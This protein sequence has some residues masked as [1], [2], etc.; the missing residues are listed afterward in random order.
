MKILI[1]SPRFPYKQGKADSMTVFHL[2]QFLSQR[3]HQVILATF[4]QKDSFPEQERTLMKEMCL[5]VRTVPLKQWRTRWRL[6][7]NSWSKK[8]FQVA[9]YWDQ[10][11][12]RTVDDLIQK[13]QPDVSY[14]HLIRTA[15]YLSTYPDMLKV[16]AMQ[17]AQTL[18][19]KRLI[20]H[21]RN[22]IRKIFYTQEYRRVSQYEPEMLTRFN[23][24]LLISPHDKEAIQ[25]KKSPN[26]VFFNP[27]GIDV[28]YF[29]EELNLERK[30]N[31]I[32]MNGDFGVPTNIDAALYFYTEIFPLVKSEIPE[33]KLWLVGRNP[34][35]SIRKLEKDPSVLVTGK[36]PD[37]RPYLQS[38]TVGI[39]PLRASAGLQNKI[40]VSLASQLPL[41]STSMANEGIKAPDGEVLLMAENTVDFADKLLHLLRDANE[42]ER[43]GTN[44]LK[45]ME[46]FW[47]WNYHFEKLEAMLL[48]LTADPTVELEN[49]YPFLTEKK[50][51]K[52]EKES[53]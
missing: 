47:T 8:P 11:M 52:T 45:Y 48:D 6:F 28:D 22:F 26:N 53:T 9:Y 38:A 31:T 34:A 40:L 30:S 14:A 18:N 27:H 42:R 19:Y 50:V 29:S 3:G 25:S 16:L 4:S 21:E 44:A 51:E 35:S 43:I 49:Y 17:I 5:E 32:V 39:A 7:I 46:K 33:T 36:V 24:I 23:R 41:V 10:E 1:I 20:R 12:K 13:H 15:E 2:I 37:I